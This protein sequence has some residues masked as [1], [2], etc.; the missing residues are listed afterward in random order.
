MRLF[1]FNGVEE[2]DKASAIEKLISQSTP[3]QDFFFMMAL[4]I[5]MAVFGILL[6]S[7]AVIIGSMLIAPLLSS[8]LSLSLGITMADYKLIRRSSQTILKSLI[9]GIAIS[10]LATLIFGA[11]KI[12]EVLI[13]N[14][15]PS[16]L[17]VAVAIV[18]GFAATFALVKPKLNETLPG[19]AIAV[20]L[21][22]PIALIGIGLAEM[23]WTMM[24]NALILLGLNIAGII[25]AGMITF[26]LMNFYTKKKVAEITVI[27]EDRKLEA[28]EPKEKPDE[29]K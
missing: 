29:D 7:V 14:S 20:A 18:A 6:G 15:S 28:E 10:A 11:G 9:I 25:F 26:S 22:P 5:L 23:S 21:I 4:S 27:K 2:D 17:A 19:V 3:S 16:L 12:P 1:I 24:T 8:V 13:I